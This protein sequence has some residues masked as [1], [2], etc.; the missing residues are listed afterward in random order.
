MSVCAPVVA[1]T[2]ILG[3]PADAGVVEPGDVGDP[4]GRTSRKLTLYSGAAVGFDDG[5]AAVRV[6]AAAASASTEDGP[7]FARVMPAAAC[8]DGSGPPTPTT[9]A[10][11]ATRGEP[12]ECGAAT[13]RGR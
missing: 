10:T 2:T 12:R 3:S 11:S 5:F 6:Y 1:S 8:A 4:T 13:W 9:V 7:D